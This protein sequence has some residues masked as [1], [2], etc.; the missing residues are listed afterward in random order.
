VALTVVVAPDSFKGTLSA[1]AAAQAIAAGWRAIRPD[2]ELVL[3]PQ[4]DGGE[5]TL[6]TI[7]S[8]VADSIRHRIGDVTGPDGRATS[9]EWLELPGGVAVAE[10]A[11]TSG[12]ALLRTPDA[13]RAS[14]RGLGEVIRAAMQDGATSLVIGLGGSASTDGGAGALGALGL[15]LLDEQDEFVSS[16]GRGLHCIVAVDRSRLLKPPPGGVTLLADVTAPLLGAT[17]AAA[18]FA[19]QKGATPAEVAELDAALAHFARL[20]GGDPDQSGAGAAGG[21]GFG[22]ASVWD[23]GIE[24]GS[25]YI[26]DLTGLTAAVPTADLL[27]TG[28]GMFDAQS[29]GGKVTGNALAVAAAASVRAGVIAGQIGCDVPA[30][31]ASLENLAGSLSAAMSDAPRWLRVAGAHAARELAP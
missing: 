22:F 30:W 15:A 21:T 6:D 10:L 23:A 25:A 16:G 1:R 28:E 8:T 26:A 13:M 24:S 7:E 4:A 31:A 18:V 27:I 14:T 9:G 19:P 20:L 5:G 3:I 2:D 29:F 11:Q 12:V 17:G